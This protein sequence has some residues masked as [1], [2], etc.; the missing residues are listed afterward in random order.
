MGGIIQDY[1]S[2]P[3]H[4]ATSYLLAH[5]P[6]LQMQQHRPERRHSE[7]DSRSVQSITALLALRRISMQGDQEHWA[8]PPAAAETRHASPDLHNVYDPFYFRQHF[9]APVSPATQ[10]PATMTASMMMELTQQF[11]QMHTGGLQMVCEQADDHPPMSMAPSSVQMLHQY[12]A[13]FAASPQPV[14]SLERFNSSP[15]NPAVGRLR[16]PSLPPQDTSGMS[17]IGSLSALDV[18]WVDDIT[19]NMELAVQ[20]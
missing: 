5:S 15:I 6:V 13:G 1:P 8:D 10:A 11:N 19:S 12:H 3:A 14:P 4:Q 9:S 18:S 17:R 2:S 16:A 20:H 7:S